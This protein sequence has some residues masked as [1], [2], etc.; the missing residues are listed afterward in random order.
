MR[1]VLSIIFT[2][3]YTHLF[4]QYKTNSKESREKA[5]QLHNEYVKGDTL[6]YRQI[7]TKGKNDSA[8]WLEYTSKHSIKSI[9]VQERIN[10]K[11]YTETLYWYS[12]GDILHIYIYV[13]IL[14]KL[15]RWKDRG[16]GTYTFFNNQV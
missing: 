10:D 11:A 4:C 1:I 3:F 16:S 9:L 5:I 7:E 14:N 2:L 6:P 12:N 8:I 15:G 13:K